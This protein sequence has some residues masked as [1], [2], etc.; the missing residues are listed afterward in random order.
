MTSPVSDVPPMVNCVVVDV[1]V[2]EAIAVPEDATQRGVAP[3]V[4]AKLM[5]QDESTPVPAVTVPKLSLPPT[6]GDT[7]QLE[8]V[9]AVPDAKRCPKERIFPEPAS[10]DTPT[11]RP[12]LKY[13]TTPCEAVPAGVVMISKSEPQAVEEQFSNAIIWNPEPA[14]VRYAPEPYPNPKLTPIES[15]NNVW[16]G[17]AAVPPA[18]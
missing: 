9:G 16:V 8:I 12:C 4:L 11:L 17:E 3:H 7:P 10:V 13:A 1:T 15:F 6:V 5:T 2:M 18:A 14:P